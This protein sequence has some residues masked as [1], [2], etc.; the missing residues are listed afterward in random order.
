MILYAKKNRT[1]AMKSIQNV[2]NAAVTKKAVNLAQN[3][4]GI[5]FF[6]LTW[7][8]K[9]IICPSCLGNGKYVKFKRLKS[10]VDHCFLRH[11]LSCTLEKH[12]ILGFITYR[13]TGDQL[14]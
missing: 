9:P 1:N 5:N 10:F 6:K 8:K 12:T 11:G 13:L 7:K 3:V 2:T 14:D 4:Q